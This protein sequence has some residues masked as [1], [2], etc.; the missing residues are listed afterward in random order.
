VAP[1]RFIEK[2]QDMTKIV[3]PPQ[4][5]NVADIVTYAI[6]ACLI[7]GLAFAFIFLE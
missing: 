4:P 2:V 6:V 5:R 1:H 3:A 7:V